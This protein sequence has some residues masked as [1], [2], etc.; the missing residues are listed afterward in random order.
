MT[1]DLLDVMGSDL[2]VVNSARVSF[3]K[4]SDWNYYRDHDDAD[5]VKTYL[6]HKDV[7][8]FKVSCQETNIGLRL[9]ILSYSSGSLL[10]CL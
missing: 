2:T 8:L 3:D 5:A 10:L 4:A 9:A 1:V 6:K 7:K